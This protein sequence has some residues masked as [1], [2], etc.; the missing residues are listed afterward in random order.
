M[1]LQLSERRSHSR[2][3]PKSCWQL[4]VKQLE[5]KQLEVKKLE[6]KQQQ[7]RGGGSVHVLHLLQNLNSHLHGRFFTFAPSNW[8]DAI[9]VLLIEEPLKFIIVLF[10]QFFQSPKQQHIHHI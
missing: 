9:Q 7:Q 1:S 5:V 4:E 2:P 6:V 8:F 3:E 10:A